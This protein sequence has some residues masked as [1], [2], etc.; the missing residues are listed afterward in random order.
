MELIFLLP[1]KMMVY[2]K[3]IFADVSLNLNG[4]KTEVCPRE[5]SAGVTV[6][7]HP[8]SR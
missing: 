6:S 5:L 2:C 8:E 1:P 3:C 7:C 4:G